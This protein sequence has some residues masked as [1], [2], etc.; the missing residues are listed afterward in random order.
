[1][2]LPLTVVVAPLRVCD[3]SVANKDSLHQKIVSTGIERAIVGT[4]S[5]IRPLPIR[6]SRQ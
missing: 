2:V 4:I 3:S 6:S 5:R 1:M